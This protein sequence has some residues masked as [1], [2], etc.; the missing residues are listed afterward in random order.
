MAYRKT[1]GRPG[2]TRMAM[3]PPVD[4][5]EVADD[6]LKS[7]GQRVLSMVQKGGQKL[8][9]FDNAYANKVREAIYPERMQGQGGPM[10]AVR[11]MASQVAGF[12][13]NGQITNMEIND[14]PFFGERALAA[15]M[16]Y[17]VPAAAAGIRYGLPAAG[18]VGLAQLT[19]GL[20]DY[21]SEQPLL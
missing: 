3:S 15:A 6:L 10:G 2:S 11:G 4:T 20:Y 5:Q 1:S 13:L 8:N 19:N 18:A 17:G 9:E 16:P 12:P 21:A 7:I 14:N